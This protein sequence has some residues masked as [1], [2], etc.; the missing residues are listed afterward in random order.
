MLI[1]GK[2]KHR[3][4]KPDGVRGS[5]G[6]LTI[7]LRGNVTVCVNSNTKSFICNK[8]NK[9][10]SE[11]FRHRG[12]KSCKV[13]EAYRV[14]CRDA[15]TQKTFNE[16]EKDFFERQRLAEAGLRICPKCSGEFPKEEMKR[17]G[18]GTCHKEYRRIA[19][20]KERRSAA[21]RAG[22]NY[23]EIPDRQGKST[24]HGAVVEPERKNISGSIW[25]FRPCAALERAQDGMARLNAEQALRW[26]LSAGASDDYVKQW[27]SAT[28]KPWNNPRLSAAEKFK[29]RYANDNE[30]SIRQ[31]IRRQITK[32]IKR[33]G[34]G[35]NM[36]SALCRDGNSSV[37]ERTLGYTIAQ[38]KS[39]L[40]SLF[41]DGMSWDEFRA[42]NIHIDHI[43]PQA[44]FDLS[45]DDDYQRCWS[46]SNLQPLWATD[47]L[48]KSDIMPCGAFARNLQKTT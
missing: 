27:F 47:N 24:H 15:K 21:I 29:V 13:C 19:K 17:H 33:D 22:K 36:R 6:F 12:G 41:T 8:C 5:T 26:W 43:I 44:A 14:H 40:E 38:L 1:I 34:I 42:G 31:R 46:L 11:I 45:R 4:T 23:T 16:I 32:K 20:I 25:Y 30:F 18:C 39:H 3:I 35:D 2:P 7:T 28:G 10:R 37:V 9:S 48:A